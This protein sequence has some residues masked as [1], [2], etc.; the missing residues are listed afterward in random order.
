MHP[1][2]ETLL[3]AGNDLIWG[4]GYK[5]ADAALAAAGSQSRY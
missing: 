5:L 4:I 1:N 3:D 2:F